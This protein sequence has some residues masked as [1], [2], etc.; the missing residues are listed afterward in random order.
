MMSE[1]KPDT[2]KVVARRNLKHEACGSLRFHICI[3]SDVECGFNSESMLLTSY[4]FALLFSFKAIKQAAS[5]TRC[6]RGIMVGGG[7]TRKLAKARPAVS[8]FWCRTCV[9]V[10]V[11]GIGYSRTLRES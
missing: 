1:S 10:F 5:T 2:V 6:Y 9:T 8:N 11:H 3:V 4:F 7:S